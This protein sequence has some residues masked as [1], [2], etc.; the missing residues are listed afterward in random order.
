M[1]SYDAD[2]GSYDPDLKIAHIP[3]ES[4]I[5]AGGICNMSPCKGLR[6]FTDDTLAPVANINLQVMTPFQS[7]RITDLVGGFTDERWRSC[8]LV[9]CLA[10]GIYIVN[11]RRQC[12]IRRIRLCELQTHGW[13][14][15]KFAMAV[16]DKKLAVSHSSV[17]GFGDFDLQCFAQVHCRADTKRTCVATDNNSIAIASG[18]IISI[19]DNSISRLHILDLSDDY[20]AEFCLKSPNS[21]WLVVASYT[22]NMITIAVSFTE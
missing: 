4:L 17:V 11:C 10:Q 7:V 13:Q 20:V 21:H 14:L 8:V 5:V 1:G 3:H 18:A 15:D 2:F 12:I 6:L 16:I 9:G 19:F 22:K